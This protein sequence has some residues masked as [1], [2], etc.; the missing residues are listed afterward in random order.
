MHGE[1]QARSDYGTETPARITPGTSRKRCFSQL[2][3]PEA[4]MHI[5]AGMIAA[6]Y[7]T[8]HFLNIEGK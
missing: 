2:F 8:E 5:E 6:A 1:N 7:N 3:S 4:H